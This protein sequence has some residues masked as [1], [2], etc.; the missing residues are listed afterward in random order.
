MG[1]FT[2]D[3]CNLTITGG[4]TGR[5]IV[6]AAL[7]E[8]PGFADAVDGGW[9]NPWVAGGAWIWFPDGLVFADTVK[10]AWFGPWGL[11]GGAWIWIAPPG[12]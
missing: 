11:G 1:I 8:G 12:V 6:C 4:T 9:I 2:P 7:P 10:G 5:G 3:E